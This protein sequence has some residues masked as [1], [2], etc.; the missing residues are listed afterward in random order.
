MTAVIRS[1]SNASLRTKIIVLFLLLIAAPLGVQSAITFNNF[2]SVL[3]KQAVG[4]TEQIIK[5][6]NTELENSLRDDMQRFALMVLYNQE[7]LNILEKHG[8]ASG[9]SAHS[10]RSG[11]TA[12]FSVYR[13]LRVLSP[14]YQ[15]CANYYESGLYL[16]QCA[17]QRYSKVYGAGTGEMDLAG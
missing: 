6:M 15:G 13:R 3:N 1:F 17:S 14:L 2:S 9:V 4:Y 11:T 10:F 12:Y 8:D 5:Q 16:H 7:L